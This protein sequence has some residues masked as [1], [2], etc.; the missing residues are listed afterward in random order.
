L[1]RPDVEDLMRNKI[2]DKVLH[3]HGYYDNPDSVILDISS[4]SRIS[5]DPHTQTVIRAF[6]L[7]N[8][9]LFIGCGDTF[10]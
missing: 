5:T 8:T 4:Y 2:R 9:L 1:D 3:L 6:S 10:L 7:S